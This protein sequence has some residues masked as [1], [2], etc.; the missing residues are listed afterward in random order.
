[1]TL[2]RDSVTRFSIH[3][4]KKKTLLPG[5][6][7]QC[8]KQ[9]SEFSHFCEVL[10]CKVQNFHVERSQRLLRHKLLALGTYFL[11]VLFY[12]QPCADTVITTAR[13]PHVPTCCCVFNYMCLYPMF[14][15][16]NDCL[17]TPYLD[18]PQLCRHAVS[19]TVQ[20]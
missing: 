10:C 8:P 1:M 20:I 11:W 15:I 19:H 17:Q 12:Q 14:H 6:L 5:P 2:K 18:T 7:T 16:A 9:L 4:W 13:C 3:F